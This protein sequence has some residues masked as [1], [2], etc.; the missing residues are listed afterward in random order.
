MRGIM[1]RSDSIL[2]TLN[3]ISNPRSGTTIQVSGP[4]KLSNG[5]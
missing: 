5:H 2:A 4:L 1:N 3:V